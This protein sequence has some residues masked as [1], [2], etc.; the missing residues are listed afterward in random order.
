LLKRGVRFQV[1]ERE[2]NVCFKLLPDGCDGVFVVRQ[3]RF[4]IGEEVGVLF[5][6]VRQSLDLLQNAFCAHK[7]GRWCPK[8][9]SEDKFSRC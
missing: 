5:D 9:G 7:W 1:D 2:A 3:V 4:K 6:E 8:A